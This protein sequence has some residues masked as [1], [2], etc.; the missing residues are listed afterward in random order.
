MNGK[1]MLSLEVTSVAVKPQGPSEEGSEVGSS[2]LF[3]RERGGKDV[4][5]SK[6]KHLFF[7]LVD[8]HYHWQ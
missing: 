1:S 6:K 3:P 5:I 4:F 2:Y 7:F 8:I